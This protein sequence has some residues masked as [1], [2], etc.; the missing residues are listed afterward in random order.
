MKWW[1]RY[2]C[3][4]LKGLPFSIEFNI[5]VVFSPFYRT[6]NRKFIVFDYFFP[7][8]KCSESLLFFF[9]FHFLRAIQID[10]DFN[11]LFPS[12]KQIVKSKAATQN[13]KYGAH[14]EREPRQSKDYHIFH[15]LLLKRALRIVK[16]IIFDKRSN[17][18]ENEV[19]TTSNSKNAS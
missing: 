17:K 9:L 3:V 1:C 6:S 19:R 11:R 14:W 8:Y 5:V 4:R 18:N 15:C 16:R 12:A 2:A 13:G 7:V 10:W